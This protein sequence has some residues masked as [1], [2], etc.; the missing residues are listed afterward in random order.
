MF[1]EESTASGSKV[2]IA[3]REFRECVDDIEVM[4]VQHTGMQFTWSQ[5]PK[6]GH[7]I[8]KKL[9]RILANLEF[10]DQFIGAYA[11][12]KPYRISDHSPSVLCIPTV[13]KT[14]PKPFKFFNILTSHEK[15]L[16]VV[17]QEWAMN[18][19]GFHMY[20]VV[21]KLK[22]LK[23]PFRK[24]LYD[25]GNIHANV[26]RLRTEL[27]SIQ[28]SLDTD[29]FNIVLRE[30]EASC[31]VEFNQ[32]ILTEE[33][34]LKQKAKIQWLKEGDSNSSYFHKVVKSRVSR[35]RIDVVTSSDGTV[36]ENDLVHD[37]FV[38]H[39]ELFLGQVGETSEFCTDNLFKTCLNDQEALEM[40]RDVTD[41]EI[42]DALFSIGD[43]KS[44]GPDGF[45]AAFFKEAWIVI[46]QDIYNAVR[47]FFRNGTMLK[48]INHTII[49]LLPKVKTPTRVT[50]F[51]PISCCN[52]LFKCISKLIANRIK[53]CLKS[54]ISANQSAFVPGRSITDNILLT[55]ELM[56]NYHLNRGTPR[57]AFKVDIQKAY[58]TVDWVFLRS[59]LVGFGFHEKMVT[60]IMECVT[61]TSYS[62]CVNGSLH[63]HF[64]GSRGL[65]QGDPLSPYLFTMVMEIL[66]LM[67][68]RRVLA[69]DCFTYHRYCSNLEL[70]NLCFADDLFLFTYGDVAS[71]SVI[72]EALDEFKDASGLI[73]SIPKSTAY[74]C[75][76]LNHTKLSILQVL[77]F[78]EGKLPVKYL[79]VP[80]VSSRLKI[81][82][83]LELVDKV[84]LRIQDWKKKSLSMARRLQLIQAVLGSLHIFWASVFI[85]PN[86]VLLNIEHT[87]RQFLCVNGSSTKGKSTVAVG[88]VCLPKREGGLGIRRL[89]C[90]NSAIMSSHIWN[91]LTLK[92]SL[93]VKWVHEY[94]I[95]DRNIWT[96]R[97]GSS[98]S[99]SQVWDD[100]R[101]RDNHVEWEIHDLNFRGSF[102]FIRLYDEVRARTLFVLSSSNRGRLLGII[103]LMRQKNKRMKQEGLI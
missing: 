52:V 74:F 39:Y 54:I 24:L 21:K 101:C 42:K 5:K 67:I 76:V 34:F 25:K 7:G 19:S 92:E 102:D 55:Q 61:T 86:Q 51:R 94:K 35:N 53:H 13:C 18:V 88:I 60:W 71:A 62:I 26:N 79:G 81:R 93:W 95:K 41:K 28:L 9:D 59:I 43:D 29:P 44:P 97:Y 22:I 50:D 91:L 83:C 16:D 58:D 70:V 98:F 63:G 11:I 69:S 65:R 99:V 30:R 66:T 31:I 48:E 90:F 87:M 82:D 84:S 36:F 80:L 68:Q 75:N 6:G 3:V 89:H 47:E 78:E 85:I 2:D 4:D 33:R 73:P 37:A 17:K 77:P 56:H 10:F 12:F 49:A 15:F 32:A 20:Q 96:F 27:D 46:G 100:I 103:D 45:S 38:K 23:K 8:F 1:L 57:C 64:K 72:M 40:V 14:K